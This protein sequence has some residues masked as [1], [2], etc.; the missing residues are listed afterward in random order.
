[1]ARKYTYGGRPG[2]RV[3]YFR[4]CVP[5]SPWLVWPEGHACQLSAEEPYEG[6]ALHCRLSRLIGRRRAGIRVLRVW[7]GVR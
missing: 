2:Y 4:Q 1:M 6:G 7:A 5:H 3:D